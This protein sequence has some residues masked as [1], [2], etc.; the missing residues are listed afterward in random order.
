[1]TEVEMVDGLTRADAGKVDAT[2]A[3]G[4]ADR[5]EGGEWP[6]A[7]TSR[8][9]RAP[10][11]GE[12]A[13]EGGRSQDAVRVPPALV[14]ARGLRME[15]PRGRSPLPLEGMM[16]RKGALRVQGRAPRVAQTARDVGAM[17]FRPCKAG[18]S[19]EFARISKLLMHL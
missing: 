10:L 14:A 1:M 5:R 8:H 9:G 4:D 7:M 2:T 16:G 17:P 3:A 12:A 6:A 15:P 13:S 19:S 18:V 11:R